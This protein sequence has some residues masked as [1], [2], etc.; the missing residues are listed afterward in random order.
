MTHMCA[1]REQTRVLDSLG[2]ELEMI[3]SHIMG[4]GG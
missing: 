3:V 2:F 1:H 4:A